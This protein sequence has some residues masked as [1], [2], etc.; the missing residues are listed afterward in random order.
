MTLTLARIGKNKTIEYAF[1]ELVRCLGEMDETLFLD[2]RVY[3]AR[4]LSRDDI[5]WIGLDGT[6][7]YSID[8]EIH[9]HIKNGGG[10]ITGSNERS[11]L[12]AVY[13]VLYELGCRFI[14]P[15]KDGELL[16]HQTIQKES[17]N[18]QV[19]EKPSY[20]H[21]GVCIEGTNDYQHVADMIE[22]LPKIGMNGYFVQN[23]VP[24]FFINPWYSHDRNPL[25]A[26]ENLSREDVKH[27]WDR[28]EEEVIKRGLMYHAVGHGWTCEPFGI[29]GL[30]WDDTV[31]KEALGKERHFAQVNGVRKLW[32]NAGIFTN[33]C[34]SNPETRQIVED[35]VVD[36]CKENPAVEYLHFWLADE[37]NNQCECE[38]CRKMSPSDFYVVMLN[39]LDEKLTKAGLSTKI[40]FLLYQELLWEPETEKIKNPDRFALMFAPISRTYTFAYA[41]DLRIMEDEELTPFVRNKVILPSSVAEN[42]T[43]LSRWQQQFHGDS[44]DFDYH[45]MWDHLFDPGYYECAR[46]LHKDMVNLDKIGLNGMVSCQNQR[47]FYPTGLPMYAMARGLW[48]KESDFQSIVKEYFT[49]SFGKD[50]QAVEDY[51]RTLSTLFHPPYLRKELPQVSEEL[52]ADFAKIIPVVQAFQAEYIEPNKDK[53]LSWKY[54][55]YH[56]QYC[57]LLADTLRLRASGKQEESKERFK[58]W[59]QYLYETEMQTHR[60]LDTRNAL[61]DQVFGPLD[62]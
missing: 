43:R 42:V 38:N 50:A 5:L 31:P 45:I 2:R 24:Y 49:A 54:L 40:V 27:I 39:E 44:F 29:D 16:A 22:W 28:L 55:S 52:A 6:L 19:F 15:G 14:R 20:R 58:Q 46:V 37:Y 34:Y 21:R 48:D 1:D 17:L 60:V 9:I 12:I 25:L 53:D 26:G 10:I 57:I 18:I 3:D 62:K 51:M 35:A 47:V 36:Y 30:F 32:N 13:R 4:D 59:Q 8:D 41:D 7:P 11:V 33:L 61:T 23:F 56:A